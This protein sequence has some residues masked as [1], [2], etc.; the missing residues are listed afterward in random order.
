MQSAIVPVKIFLFT[1]GSRGI[2]EAIATGAARQGFH[3]VLTFAHDEQRAG[4]VVDRI[5]SA[6]GSASGIGQHSG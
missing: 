4:A 3:V 1:G 2:G 6:G 5:R